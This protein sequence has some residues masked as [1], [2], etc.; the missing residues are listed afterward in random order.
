[1]IRFRPYGSLVLTSKEIN[2]D[3][4]TG[5]GSILHHDTFQRNSYRCLSVHFNHRKSLL[6]A[7]HDVT[8]LH[9]FVTEGMVSRIDEVISVLDVDGS[10]V[11]L[12]IYTCEFEL[13]PSLNSLYLCQLRSRLT[14]GSHNT[15]RAEVTLMRAREVE[16]GTQAAFV[17]TGN[18]FVRFIDSLVHPVPDSTTYGSS[19]VFDAFPIFLQVTDGITHR[20]SVF[21][22]KHRL[23]E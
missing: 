9:D 7:S 23:V 18:D 16:T 22:D 12:C 21:A 6:T 5:L 11:S 13:N 3:F 10:C 14:V 2:H 20:V 19:R 17:S 1:M 8:V 4:F 15:V